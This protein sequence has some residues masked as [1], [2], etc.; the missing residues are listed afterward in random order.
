MHDL[1]QDKRLAKLSYY[2]Y[3][4]ALPDKS[5]HSRGLRTYCCTVDGHP[6]QRTLEVPLETAYLRTLVTIVTSEQV[7]L[8]V[9]LVPLEKLSRD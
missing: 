2:Q 6:D 5:E 7:S 4:S 9:F 1:A 8:V 3:L